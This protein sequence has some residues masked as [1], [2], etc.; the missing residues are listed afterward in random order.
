MTYPPILGGELA[1]CENVNISRHRLVIP[2][3]GHLGLGLYFEHAKY[4]IRASNIEKA[5]CEHSQNEGHQKIL[6][7]ILG[8]AV[9][10][11]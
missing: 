11:F 3:E 10:F 4:F 6:S 5:V 1:S 9:E 2:F 8:I 7:G